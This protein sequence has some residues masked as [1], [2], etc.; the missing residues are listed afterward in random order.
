MSER[1]TVAGG[2]GLESA[3]PS[4][5]YFPICFEP[6][7]S[8]VHEPELWVLAAGERDTWGG[9]TVAWS[10]DDDWYAENAEGE[11]GPLA[12]VGTLDSHVS[13]LSTWEGVHVELPFRGRLRSGDAGSLGRQQTLCYLGNSFGTRYELLCYSEARLV[14]LRDESHIYRF[15]GAVRRGCY[16]TAIQPF[17]PGTRFARLDAQVARIALPTRLVEARATLRLRIVSE[18]GD[19]A[20]EEPEDVE[21]LSYTIQGIWK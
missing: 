18:N 15:D 5:A 13:I 1:S 6:P 17:A 11:I 12:V 10:E 21:P 14:G 3:P 4:P 9:A 8:L 2:A 7:F 16:G 20:I 19:E